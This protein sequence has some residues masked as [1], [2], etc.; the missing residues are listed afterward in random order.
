MRCDDNWIDGTRGRRG[1]RHAVLYD[2]AAT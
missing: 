1:R 2:R